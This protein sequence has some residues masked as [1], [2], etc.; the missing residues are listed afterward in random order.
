MYSHILFPT[1]GSECADAALDHAL[2]HAEMYDATIH[3]LYVA[4][5][6][7]VG[8]A[9]PAVSLGKVRDA[10]HDSGRDV[11]E[12]VARTARAAGIDVETT[13]TEGTP[14]SEILEFADRDDI[15]LVVMG[16][17]GRSGL[18][19]YLIGSVAERVVR[20]SPVPVLTVRQEPE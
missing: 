11:L 9:A 14:E 16:T 2:D 8:H 12:R 17:H 20:S 3:A 19:R 18:D 4:D 13:V 1:D 15:D 7:E 5:V 6:R 10:L